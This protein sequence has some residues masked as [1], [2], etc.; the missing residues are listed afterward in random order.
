MN[1]TYDLHQFYYDKFG[2]IPDDFH[3]GRGHFGI[4]PIPDH[5]VEEVTEVPYQQRDFYEVSLVRRVGAVI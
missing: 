5:S 3:T 4:F 1:Q 2:C